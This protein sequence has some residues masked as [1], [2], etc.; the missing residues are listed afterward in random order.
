MVVDNMHRNKQVLNTDIVLI[1]VIDFSKLSPLQQLEIINFI[2]SAYKKMI[3]QML[4][5]S[6]MTLDKL[7][8]GFISTGDGFYSI[9][10]PR[11]KGYGVI[12]GLSFSHLSEQISKRFKYFKGMKVAVHTGEVYQFTDILGQKNYIGDGLNDCARYLE[13]KNFSISTVMV[14]EYAYESLKKFLLMF[15]DFNTLLIEKGFKYSELHSFKDKHFQERKGSLVWLREPGIISPPN[16]NFNS[17]LQN[18]EI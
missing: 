6:N 11:L 17:I 10:N 18:K 9:L 3:E 2:T 14:S 1:D 5:N 4:S 12:L 13:V 8:L 7:I 15:K 16:I